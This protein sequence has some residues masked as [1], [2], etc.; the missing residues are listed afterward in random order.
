MGKSLKELFKGSPFDKAVKE[1]RE[2]L[3]EQE[4]SGI[5]VRSLVEVNNP[6]IYG[7][8]AGRI[9]LRS[10]PLLEEMKSGTGTSSDGGGIIGGKITEIRNSV[11]SEL[12][13]LGV[14][15]A[16]IPTKVAKKIKDISSQEPITLETMGGNVTDVGKALKQSGGG[17][18]KTIGKQALGSGISYGKDKLRGE[19][20]GEGQGIG[21]AQSSGGLG[22]KEY[23]V[24][25]TTNKRTYSDVNTSKKYIKSKEELEK[26]IPNLSLISPIYGVTR[27]GSVEKGTPPGRFGKTE[28][29]FEHKGIKDADGNYTG[30]GVGFKVNKYSNEYKKT[31]KEG[32][33]FPLSDIGSKINKIGTLTPLDFDNIDE[34]GVYKKGEVEVAKDLIPFYIGKIGEKKTPFRALLTGIT[35]TVSPS[36]NTNKML[37]NPFPFYTYSQIER[38]TAFQLKIATFNET[39]LKLNWER[40]EQLTKMT[41]PNINKSKLVNPPIID[42]RLGDIYYNK[43][44]FIENL[45]YT[46]PDNS[47]WETR[48]GHSYLPKFIE[49][50]VSIKFIE[51]TSVLSNLYGFKR[52][53]TAVEKIKEETKSNS[54]SESNR[55]GTVE[56]G[57]GQFGEF[58]TDGNFEQKI[59]VTTRGI[60]PVGDTGIESTGIP[61][62]TKQNKIKSAEPKGIA[63]TSTPIEAE[64]GNG[65][66]P[67]QSNVT[68]NLDGSKTPLEFASKQNTMTEAQSLVF[69]DLKQTYPTLKKIS[70][71]GLPKPIQDNLNLDIAFASK[72]K[73]TAITL[74]S[75][76]ADGTNMY[77]MVFDDGDILQDYL[78]PLDTVSLTN[79][80]LN[81]NRYNQNFT[82]G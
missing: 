15:F 27:A 7:N 65:E 80:N 22:G 69:A 31:Q 76:E 20:F 5:R 10:T 52:S 62:T 53:K 73:E 71:I 3:V 29:A 40:I 47:V 41:Y 57:Q 13:K 60:A 75:Y 49:V 55:T 44:G 19:L 82:K 37:G 74:E 1:D 50:S 2:T 24:E 48:D 45:T 8:E 64:T 11:N 78:A 34:N 56:V 21:T 72:N 30:K 35:E 46:I 67:I 39:E 58:G 32:Q 18:P 28:Y 63:K 26:V 81:A 14:P 61:R 25:Y 38:S 4:T 36:W 33:G 43:I 42:F 9:S 59:K 68:D 17:N 79:A 51:D 54:F 66:I 16:Q 6:L 70:F 12:E 77:F 23:S